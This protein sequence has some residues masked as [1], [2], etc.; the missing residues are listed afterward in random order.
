MG[1]GKTCQSML[2]K[3]R[4]MIPFA[5]PMLGEEEVEATA[6][7][8]RSGWVTAG[9][10]VQLF[11]REFA[12]YTGAQYA[13][14]VSNCTTALHLAMKAIGLKSGDEV[15]TVSHSFIATANCIRY[16]GAIPVFVDV[17]PLTFN[18]DPTRIEQVITSRTRAILCVHQ[19]GMPCN[20]KAILDIASRYR[21]KVVE[22]AAPAVGS[23]IL[24][25]GDWH[26]IGRP[27]ADI[28]CFSFQARKTITTGD[29]GMLTT[30]DPEYDRMF[31]RWRHHGCDLPDAARHAMKTVQFEEYS[32]VGYNY[33]LTDIQAAIGR[34]QLQ[35]LP[36]IVRRRRELAR[37]YCEQLSQIPGV[38]LPVEPAW[39]RSNWQSFCIMLP[40]G[41]DQL[42]VM[43]FMLDHGVAVRRG[44][45]TSHMEKAYVD[46][47]W[48]CGEDRSHCGC[49]HLTCGRLIESERGRLNG[50]LL[51][52]FAE[53][54]DAE[55]D[56]VVKCLADAIAATA[57]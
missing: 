18:I 26:K 7:V 3:V 31:R 27:H 2:V 10:E 8:I 12:A 48:L 13:C 41:V 25:D 51:P 43:Q 23:E 1:Y 29:G 56:K 52:M 50:L 42:K 35:R 21:L 30:N 28:A 53:L 55:Q 16:L 54:S 45:H 5:K 57:N 38:G 15:I 44:V 11:E 4:F 22:D 47:P 49:P 17:E 37:R 32:E 46:E 33:R 36:N 24:W 19:V 40:E 14:A 20:L 9:P 39:A 6:R 34:V